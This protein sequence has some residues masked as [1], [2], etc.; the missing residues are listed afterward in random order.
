MCSEFYIIA[1]NA[2]IKDKAEHTWVPDFIMSPFWSNLCDYK[3]MDN[4]HIIT[5]TTC[6][7]KHCGWTLYIQG[8]LL[9]RKP[10]IPLPQRQH[11]NSMLDFQ[12]WHEQSVLTEVDARMIKLTWC[13]RRCPT[14]VSHMLQAQRPELKPNSLILHLTAKSWRVWGVLYWFSMKTKPFSLH[15]NGAV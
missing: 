14:F 3:L 2:R 10:S 7:G 8:S 15:S 6:S 13:M 4:G 9:S 12:E 1:W 5:P 11:S